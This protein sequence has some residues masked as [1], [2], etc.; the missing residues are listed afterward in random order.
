M[1]LVNNPGDWGHVYSP[2]LHAHWH[3][4]TPTDLIFP[5]FLWIV[6]VAIPLSTGNRLAA[7]QTRADL[8]RHGLRRAVIIFALGLF[9]N[10]LSYLLNGSLVRLGFVDWVREYLTSVRIPGV[11]QRI[12]VCYLLSL[13]LYLLTSLRWQ[14]AATIGVLLAYWI[15][16]TAVPVPGLGTASLERDGNLSQ[17]VD[18][19]VLSGPVIGNHMWK[20]SRTW[21]P[22][23]ILSTLPAIGTCMFG[24]FAGRLLRA[25]SFPMPTK[26]AWLFLGGWAA[27]LLGLVMNTWL[28][29]N[30]NLWT[31][32]Y[33][34]FIAGLSA[35]SF[36]AIYWIVDVQGWRRWSRPFAI[37]GLNAIAVF[38]L[39]G[40]LGRLMADI[41]FG[42]GEDAVG[43]KKMLYDTFFVSWGKPESVP[44]LGSLADPRN[45]SLVWALLWVLVLYLVAWFMH[46]RKWY[47]KF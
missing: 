38:V 23:G 30:K 2:L 13:L 33:A 35:T 11:L 26:T 45:P 7:G 15:L 27:T 46:S 34:V 28:P 1:M 5:F 42:T 22:E 37:Y 36:A 4:W 6:G 18:S 29:I 9:L 16:M 10:S 43:L 40:V 44:W 21:D 8:A 19:A 17:Y 24:V 12:A 20:T 14:I 25:E 39:S 47:V 31:S 3:G 41:K 32:S